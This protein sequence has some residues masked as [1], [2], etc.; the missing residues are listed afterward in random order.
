VK[1]WT[2]E[3]I[4]NPMPIRYSAVEL[5]EIFDKVNIPN[6]QSNLSKVKASFATAL[7]AYCTK[8]GCKK[9]IN[10]LP[11]PPAAKVELVNSTAVGGGGGGPYR[12]ASTNPI[13][14]VKKFLVYSGSNIDIIQI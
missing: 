1:T 5:T 14:N 7:N 12:W 11:K 13:T 3:V 8:V 6:I 2:T 9:A 10:D 4:N